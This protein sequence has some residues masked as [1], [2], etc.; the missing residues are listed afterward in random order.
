MHFNE[1]NFDEWRSNLTVFKRKYC[2]KY[3]C[4]RYKLYKKTTDQERRTIWPLQRY[5][6]D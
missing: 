5:C 2:N 4:W 3:S 6:Q 1:L